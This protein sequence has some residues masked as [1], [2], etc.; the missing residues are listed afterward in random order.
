RDDARG[1]I[2]KHEDQGFFLRR[3]FG[4]GA[5][6]GETFAGDVAVG[7]VDVTEDDAAA[8]VGVGR[9]DGGVEA[10]V[11]GVAAVVV[12]HGNPLLRK[13]CVDGAGGVA[14]FVY[15]KFAQACGTADFEHP[16]GQTLAFFEVLVDVNRR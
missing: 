14:A 6:A 16:V 2:E 3:E 12:A 1:Q 15:L 9:G 10:E 11:L 4:G 8:L 5:A 7:N 13:F